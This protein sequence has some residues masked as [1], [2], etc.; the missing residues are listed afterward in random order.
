MLLRGMPA[1]EGHRLLVLAAQIESDSEPGAV[2]D[3]LA[4]ELRMTAAWLD[5]DSL[6]VVRRG[7]LA[8]PLA[9]TVRP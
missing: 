3:A 7:G 4:R 8:R 2:A 9:G 6:A 5:L 1:R